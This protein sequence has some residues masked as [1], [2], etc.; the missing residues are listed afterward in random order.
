MLKRAFAYAGLQFAKLQFRA[1]IDAVQPMTDFFSKA[2]TILLVLPVG[3]EESVIAGKAL[4]KLHDRMK[5]MHVVIVHTGTRATPL[6]VLPRSEVVR[7]DQND[8]N[9]FSLPRQSLLHRILPRHYDVAIDLNLDFV[10]HTAYICKVTRAAVRVGFEHDGDDA[11]FNVQMNVDRQ[12]APQA[13]F[14]HAAT[15]LSMF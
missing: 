11:F 10:L 13:R 1:D 12:R 2:G 6:S 14:E 4:G 9:K 15:F 7:I 8:I 5:N 3:Y